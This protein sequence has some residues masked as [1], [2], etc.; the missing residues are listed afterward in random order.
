MARTLKDYESFMLS[1]LASIADKVDIH[2]EQTWEEIVRNPRMI[3]ILNHGAP[4]SWIPST[5]L[6]AT[7]VSKHGGSDRVPRGIVDRWFYTNPI[8]KPLAEYISQSD[9]PLSFEEILQHF[10]AA[11][12]TDLVIFPEGANTFF[13][14]ALEIQP[15]RSPKF[16]ELSIR[17]QAPLLLAVHKGSEAWSRPVA[18]S[19]AMAQWILPFSKFFGEK[20]LEKGEVQLP[21]LDKIDC[22][23]MHVELY[24]PALYESDLPKQ[25]EERKQV[26]EEEAEKIRQHMSDILQ[27]L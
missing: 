5:A 4:L 21:W 1:I 2:T 16:V 13:G 15:F 23:K 26:L 14:N 9:K 18:V 27:N 3:A 7:E 12:R 17:A 6:L 8:T 24:M 25:A 10:Q 11:Q 20:L 19:T 22:L